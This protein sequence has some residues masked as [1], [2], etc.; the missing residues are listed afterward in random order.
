MQN[1]ELKLWSRPGESANDFAR[2]CHEAAEDCADADANKIRDKLEKKRSSIEDAIAKAEDRV[3]ELETQAEGA[4]NKSIV[5][6]GTSILGGLLGG[7][8][9]SSSLATAARRAASG[10]KSSSAV[11][12]RLESARNRAVEKIEDL[13]QLEY[14]LQEA[15]IEIDDEWNQ[16]AAAVETVE[17]PLEKTDINV[18]DIDFLWLP[19]S[20]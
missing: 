19:R 7:R 5:D 4:R 13:D 10:N 20:N 6:I 9:R 8:K 15:M 2:R 18:K 12:A 3:A 1:P 11:K 17:V 14:D 16:K